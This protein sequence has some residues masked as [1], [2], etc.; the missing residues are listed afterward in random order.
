MKFIK[1][2]A[3][4]STMLIPA[5]L[6]AKPACPAREEGVVPWNTPGLMEGDRWAWVYLTINTRGTPTNCGIGEN[7]LSQGAR[8]KVC[9][10]FIR[11]WRATPVLKDGK[12]TN[13]TIKR[14]FVIIGKKHEKAYDEARKTYFQQHPEERPECYPK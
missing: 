7:N 2:V 12:P 10:S 8:S 4:L 13:A 6:Q 1:Q 9:R 11:N 14:K 5:T 3:L